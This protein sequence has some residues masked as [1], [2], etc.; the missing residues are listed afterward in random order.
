MEQRSLGELDVSAIGLGCMG[1]SEFYGTTDDGES[2]YD[3]LERQLAEGPVITV[4]T[5]TL[6]SDANGAAH[7]DSSAAIASM[8]FIA[9]S[10]ADACGGRG[11]RD[12]SAAHGPRPRYYPA[13]RRASL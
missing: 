11:W 1:M 3:D 9:R 12:P 6:E 4:P 8:V 10:P 7:A 2:N 5:I 13:P